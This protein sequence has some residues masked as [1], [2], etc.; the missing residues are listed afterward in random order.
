MKYLRDIV[1]ECTSD[2]S[3]RLYCESCRCW[4]PPRSRHC[5]RH[6][7]CRVGF[8][9]CCPWFDGCVSVHT[10]KP[11]VAFLALA[12]A[13]LLPSA[14]FLFP[15]VSSH[16]HQVLQYWNSDELHQRWWARKRSWAV[17][18]VWRW[19]GGIVQCYRA[20]QTHHPEQPASLGAPHLKALVLF[21]ICIVVSAFAFLL[22]YYTF[23]QLGHNTLSPEVDRRHKWIKRQN[24]IQ[25]GNT[26]TR[27]WS[28][29]RYLWL[30]ANCLPPDQATATG[31]GKVIW[32][33]P[34]ITDLYDLGWAQNLKMV[35]VGDQRSPPDTLK[36]TFV[37]CRAK[38]F[39]TL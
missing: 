24:Q 1:F 17:G 28:R 26:E 6:N 13:L 34:C 36:L 21:I 27:E 9:H 20:W 25:Q 33:D 15:L 30:P 39:W 38:V 2:G 23:V 16:L 12:P 4:A 5:K 7:R 18:P 31:D 37:S 14:F 19:A 10:A 32:F 29:H 22:L 8:D 3:P 35:L 11:F